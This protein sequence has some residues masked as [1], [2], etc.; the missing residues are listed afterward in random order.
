MWL[1]S[2]RKVT[3]K[4]RYKNATY[5]TQLVEH[6]EGTLTMEV[7]NNLNSIMSSE[8]EE[9]N[10][11]AKKSHGNRVSKSKQESCK[12][13]EMISYGDSHKLDIQSSVKAQVQ[14]E[15]AGTGQRESS[16]VWFRGHDLRLDDNPAL[17]AALERKTKCYAIFLWS[18]NSFGR[19][20][21]SKP[22]LWWLRSSLLVLERELIKLGVKLLCRNGLAEE[23]LPS[24]VRE[25][26]AT[27]I[28]WNRAYEP[29]YLK[30][31]ERVISM[32]SGSTVKLVSFKSELFVE[33]WEL[34]N[35]HSPFF[36]DFHSYMRA[37][38]LQL[39]P[40]EPLSISK[41]YCTSLPY[42]ELENQVGQLDL[43]SKEDIEAFESKNNWKPGCRQAQRTLKAF[44]SDSFDKF[45]A[46]R[47]RRSLTGTSKLSPHL[48]FGELSV[49]RIFYMV[50][51]RV[52]NNRENWYLY[53]Q[54]A[55]AF[56]KNLCLREYAYHILY[57]YPNAIDTPLQSV[58]NLFPWE[59]DYSL[60]DRWSVGHTGYPMVDAA[61]RE[62]RS[63]G[64]IHN[65]LRFLL[66]SFLTRY[67][68]LPWQLGAHFLYSHLIDGD[69]AANTLGWQ[70][71]A[72]CNTDSFPLSCL[73]NPIGMGRKY[74]SSG[75]YVRQWIPEL[76]S[77]QDKY[78]HCPWQA[79]EDVLANANITLGKTY[80]FPIVDVSFARSRA[81]EALRIMRQVVDGQHL[82]KSLSSPTVNDVIEEWPDEEIGEESNRMLEET[83][84][85]EQGSSALSLLP[86]L[87]QLL[88]YDSPPSLPVSSLEHLLFNSENEDDELMLN[89]LS[90]QKEDE[91]AYFHL[92][93]R[94]DSSSYMTNKLDQ[95]TAAQSNISNFVGSYSPSMGQQHVSQVFLP[96]W[97]STPYSAQERRSYSEDV[98]LETAVYA[99]NNFHRRIPSAETNLNYLYQP[100]LDN[101]TQETVHMGPFYGNPVSHKLES[102]PSEHRMTDVSPSSSMLTFPSTKRKVKATAHSSAPMEEST[103]KWNDIS[104]HP[105]DS[106]EIITINMEGMQESRRETTGTTKRV[107]QTQLK[108]KQLMT[109]H[110]SHNRTSLSQKTSSS[111]WRQPPQTSEERRAML[112]IVAK[113]NQHEGQLFAQFL[114]QYYELTDNVDRRISRD[115]VRV[116]NMKDLFHQWC[117]DK[118]KLLK[119]YK[120][121]SFLSDILNLEVTGEWDRH[122]H[123][124]V[125]GPYVY[126]ICPVEQKEQ[127][128]EAP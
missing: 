70:W 41:Q 127:T 33:P 124:G 86:S 18:P 16:L 8:E 1:S 97:M 60:L 75:T 28:F 26:G 89:D 108:R 128:M 82:P 37:W 43:L 58:F 21:P 3:K 104:S 121:K 27:V 118:K 36:P 57:Y 15:S 6:I 4:K 14:I 40:P 112:E 123:G 10:S 93:S 103:Q 99:Q 119:I 73:V 48:K 31:E 34:Q 95:L 87:W 61:I 65:I 47:Y 11:P 68:L 120:I 110:S 79:P 98:H 78:I 22:W 76:A 92:E 109:A 63:T 111:D 25:I 50:R 54:A 64:W 52:A 101:S 126:G 45:G 102:Y 91:T 39:P 125:R 19:W 80:P 7:N 106:P 42:T 46:A 88:Q 55:K 116:R 17:L 85:T 96:T 69:L 53:S 49:K 81:K 23:E 114:L 122:L 67:L 74:D 38:M 56:L 84:M 113:D 115:F 12:D 83:S 59:R 117:P 44:L 62:L 29:I 94:D 35:D 77:L 5:T 90:F 32:F 30:A 105:D 100:F 13:P 51:K 66:A 2:E 71:T 9:C 20:Y 24:V 72:G 107:R